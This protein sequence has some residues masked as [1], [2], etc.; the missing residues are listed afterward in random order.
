MGVTR[1]FRTFE[2]QE[3]CFVGF[4]YFFVVIVWLFVCLYGNQSALRDVEDHLGFVCSSVN[5]EIYCPL[6][7]S[8]G[9][10]KQEQGWARMLLGY[11]HNNNLWYF[12]VLIVL[13]IRLLFLFHVNPCGLCDAGNLKNLFPVFSL[14][15]LCLPVVLWCAFTFLTG[16]REASS[17]S[18]PAAVTKKTKTEDSGAVTSPAIASLVAYGEGDSSDE[19]ESVS[20]EEK[21]SVVQNTRDSRRGA[22]KLP[23][24]AVR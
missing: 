15:H 24:W 2:K 12:P 14:F 21:Q 20:A 18:Q 1:S 13:L 5:F 9:R 19:E 17:F 8:Y 4:A 10:I 6:S 22:T 11:S 16:K 7:K 3:Q 23:F